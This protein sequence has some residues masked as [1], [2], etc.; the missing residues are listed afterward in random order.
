M[1]HLGGIIHPTS[2]QMNELITS[3]NVAFPESRPCFYHHKNLELVIFDKESIQLNDI[4]VLLDGEITNER[5][6]SQ[7]LEISSKNSSEL[8][9]HAYLKWGEGFIKKIEGNFALAL[10]DSKRDLLFLFRDPVGKKTL[11]WT[12]QGDYFLFSTEIKG[13]LSTGVV[14]QTP[15][16]SGLSS[17]L[18]FGYI[19]QDL[20][21]VAEVNKLLPG[22]Y[23]KTELN[24]KYSIAQYW[25]LS[26]WLETQT[27]KEESSDS[28]Y[29]EKIEE[30]I[31]D[32]LGDL[33]SMIWKLDEPLADLSTLL[34]WKEGAPHEIYSLDHQELPKPFHSIPLTLAR[35]S[36]FF[37][38]YAIIPL[39]NLVYPNYKW[40]IL[41]NIEINEELM[42]HLSSHALFKGSERHWISPRL[43]SYFDPEIFIERF[44]RLPQMG[45]GEKM[46]SYFN[47]K[48][49]L[50]DSI[51]F[52]YEKLSPPQLM[53]TSDLL[54]IP[55]RIL[56]DKTI[57][58][59]C[60]SSYIREVFELLEE[61]AL[62]QQEIISPKWIRH[63]LGYPHLVPK[64]F[65]KMWAIL[66]LEIWFRLY[67][68]QPIGR[69]SLTLM[70]DELLRM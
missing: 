20:S 63:Q 40:R 46:I 19:P 58:E 52:Q 21:P 37:R 27:E 45:G 15:S 43:Y 68:T 70:P 31:E 11:Y 67:I 47:A 25:S 8:I 12:V 55:P 42:G 41:R 30:E 59:W 28:L 4:V 57:E 69:A 35:F 61:G 62:A 26:K 13:L 3:M 51:L 29:P 2:F 24:S 38:K 33:V 65:K 60:H 32:V 6:L 17:Y 22:Y 54:R 48:T 66:V 16:L 36:P 53:S 14:P 5:E 49:L 34:T 23:L 1:A 9:V 7:Q 39:T 50:P 64:I 44:H 18:Y 56:D 10:F